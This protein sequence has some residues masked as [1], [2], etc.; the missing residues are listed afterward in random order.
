VNYHRG[1][2]VFVDAHF[3]DGL[4]LH[5]IPKNYKHPSMPFYAIKWAIFDA[6]GPVSARDVC[7]LEYGDIRLDEQGKEFG[8]GVVSVKA[9][10][11]KKFESLQ[12]I[13]FPEFNPS[14]G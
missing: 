2:H 12:P 11:R 8:F 7:W 14:R 10:E 9:S 6:P 3:S 5:L 13:N 1:N 4:M